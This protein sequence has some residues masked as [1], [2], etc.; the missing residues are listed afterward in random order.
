MAGL[1]DVEKLENYR[2]RY[3]PFMHRPDCKISKKAYKTV[4]DC[5]VHTMTLSLPLQNCLGIIHGRA[6]MHLMRVAT[7]GKYHRVAGEKSPSPARCTGAKPCAVR[8][9]PI[10]QIHL[11]SCTSGSPGKLAR[12]LRTIQRWGLYQRVSEVSLV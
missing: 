9:L 3:I 4:V 8:T 11:N 5:S 7:S 12:G 6:Q 10:L 2:R 1:R